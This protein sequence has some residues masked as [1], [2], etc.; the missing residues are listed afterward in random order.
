[1]MMALLDGVLFY[2]NGSCISSTWLSTRHTQSLELAFTEAHGD[3]SVVKSACCCCRE[4]QVWLTA[5]TSGSSPP[6][7]LHFQGPLYV[8]VLHSRDAHKLIQKT[9]ND[10]SRTFMC[11]IVIIIRINKGV[12]RTL[13]KVYP[14]FHRLFWRKERHCCRQGNETSRIW[15]LSRR[16]QCYPAGEPCKGT[17]QENP[18]KEQHSLVL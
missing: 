11:I 14:A 9:K 2:V 16:T 18:A 13:P 1:M 10:V 3:D 6:A 7:Y 17:P 15:L 5:L 8:P 4:N 12:H